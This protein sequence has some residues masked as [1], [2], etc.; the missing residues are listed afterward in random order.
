MELSEGLDMKRFSDL[1]KR[2]RW[3]RPELF[4]ASGVT[5]FERTLDDP[6][7]HSGATLF[8]RLLDKLVPDV[9]IA[10]VP[11]DEDRDALS[12][13]GATLWARFLEMG[14]LS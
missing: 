10:E 5:L 6:V 9:A 11:L 4:L 1:V 3:E 8:E 13:S 12:V 7:S 2:S 14:C